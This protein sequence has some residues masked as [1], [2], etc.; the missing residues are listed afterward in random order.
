[1]DGAAIF[2]G[3]VF[4]GLCIRDAGVRIHDAIKEASNG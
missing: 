4:V 2:F 3:L 1:M